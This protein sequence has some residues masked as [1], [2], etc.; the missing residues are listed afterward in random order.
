MKITWAINEN[1]KVIL[2]TGSENGP[3]LI[4]FRKPEEKETPKQNFGVPLCFCEK[5]EEIEEHR[6]ADM[7]HLTEKELE[8]LYGLTD[9]QRRRYLKVKSGMSCRQ[10]A[11][12]EGVD[13][14]AVQ[15]SVRVASLLMGE[16][17]L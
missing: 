8:K 16:N 9:I 14:S 15:R 2:E 10:I 5:K 11:R 7:P 4:G 13:P 6:P 12:Q 17:K 1:E 3:V